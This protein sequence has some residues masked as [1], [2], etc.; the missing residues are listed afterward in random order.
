MTMLSGWGNYPVARAQL[1]A[2]RNEAELQTLIADHPSVIARGNG[3]AYGDSAI[4]LPATLHMRHFNRMVSF[5]AGTGQLVAESGVLLGDI[6]SAFLPRGWFPAVVPGTKFVTLGGAIAA[7][8]HGK[9]HHKEGSF[10]NC[11]DWVDVMGPDGMLRR[12]SAQENSE[13]FGW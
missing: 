11:L 9:N 10:R 1:L 2:P 12:C 3:R 6:I 7:D 4:G 5:D 8:V 13:M